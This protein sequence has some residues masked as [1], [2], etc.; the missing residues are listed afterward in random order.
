MVGCWCCWARKAPKGESPLIDIC[1]N[2]IE[3]DTAK[4]IGTAVKGDDAGNESPDVTGPTVVAANYEK[5]TSETKTNEPK[6]DGKEFVTATFDDAVRS[7]ADNL[8]SKCWWE[9]NDIKHAI[10]QSEEIKSPQHTRECNDLVDTS[11]IRQISAAE[12]DSFK[13][14]TT[15]K[16]V[17]IE[18]SRSVFRSTNEGTAKY[19]EPSSQI[20][21]CDQRDANETSPQLS[22]RRDTTYPEGIRENHIQP[23]VSIDATA[24]KDGAAET[25]QRRSSEDLTSKKGSSFQMEKPYSSDMNIETP[26]P[27]KKEF[28]FDDNS[29]VAPDFNLGYGIPTI[30]GNTD[31]IFDEEAF[32]ERK[33]MI[34]GKLR[35]QTTFKP[36]ANEHE[37]ERFDNL[38][39]SG[40]TNP[41]GERPSLNADTTTSPPAS[42]PVRP[43][44]RPAPLRRG[45]TRIPVR[46]KVEPTKP[47]ME[48]VSKLLE[49]ITSLNESKW[50]E[51]IKC[52]TE[53]C[54][55]TGKYP[56]LLS[57][58]DPAALI[59]AVRTVATHANS[60]RSNLSNSGIICLGNLYKS[61]G[62]TIAQPL[63]EVLDVCVRKAASGSP[64]FI[65]TS[66][67]ST[68]AK[69]CSSSP[70]LKL[71]SIILKM[72]KTNKSAQLTLLNCMII[73]SDGMGSNL[74]KLKVLPEIMD[75][76]LNSL[77]AGSST[78]RNA[79]K[80]LV[81]LINE[82]EDVISLLNKMRKGDD[83]SRLVN[84]ALKRYTSDD[85][86][87][88]MAQLT[89]DTL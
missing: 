28:N 44:A 88:Y 54:N 47:T 33:P 43:K 10:D 64:E 46:R 34:N 29:D 82:H 79:A 5:K 60:A 73:V 84:T 59:L 48:T 78:L 66:A 21:G 52:H 3:P 17:A 40:E 7:K 49:K 80:I 86:I 85:K 18:K 25:K 65:T 76:V 87:K 27:N 16:D 51:L 50:A 61:Q 89:H 62:A 77:K 41:Q 75:M 63:G 30:I 6:R 36:A 83:A 81:G 53:L 4:P 70:A 14:S 1:D 20:H 23:T 74:V 26:K 68:L 22:S 15:I 71:C 58:C 37:S 35:Q 69:I 72:Y 9:T 24:I 45:T 67:N 32:Q 12:D 38:D 8:N 56:E 13:G 19:N 11:V 31:G 55:L 57:E 42:K 2:V 39:Q